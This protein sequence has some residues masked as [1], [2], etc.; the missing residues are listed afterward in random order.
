MKTK[1]IIVSSFLLAGL[2]AV[3]AAPPQVTGVTAAQQAGTKLVT[4]NY[5]LVLDGNQTAFVEL[6]FSQ[7]NGLTYP[8]HCE[9]VEG[10]AGAG[11]S[12]GSKSVEWNAGADWDQ[13]FTSAGKIRVIATYGSEPSGYDGG[14]GEGG[15]S[16]QADSSLLTVAWDVYWR[17]GGPP[18]TWEDSSNG[19]VGHFAVKGGNLSA[20]KVDPTEVSNA[21]WNEVAEWALSNGYTQLPLAS[22]E[23]DPELPMTGINLWQ[24]FKW[25]NAR[26]EKEGLDP[27]YYLDPSELRGDFNN[28]GQLINGSDTFTPW[29]SQDTNGNGQWDTGEQFTDAN[30][31]GIYEGLEYADLNNN[32]QYDVGRTQVFRQGANIPDYGKQLNL[33]NDR[34][35]TYW[36]NCIDWNANGYR[37]HNYDVFFKLATGGNHKKDWPWGDETPTN[38]GEFEQH[39]R[40]KLGANTLNGPVSPDSVHA[41]GYGLKHLLGNV[42]EWDEGAWESDGVTKSY[43]YGGSYLGLDKADEAMPNPIFTGWGEANSL[44]NLM[45]Q[46]PASA[47]SPA[48]GLRCVRYKD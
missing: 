12:A 36:E 46:G 45:L 29:G 30:N 16:G 11:V 5:T 2:F 47:T 18:G 9:T 37:L 38:Y 34:W 4:V 6:W 17:P 31:N 19:A 26:S 10:D 28:D 41:N 44:F 48:I 13:K 15:A 21:K 22:S 39:V 33:G 3:A 40:A 32:S 25:C 42:A 24:A 35:Y 1:I 20:I 23:A 27:A 43:V 8:I 7:N 14:G